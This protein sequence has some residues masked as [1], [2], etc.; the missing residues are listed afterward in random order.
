MPGPSEP[1]GPIYVTASN[2]KAPLNLG[3][4]SSVSQMPNF[5]IHGGDIE[6][7]FV[8]D[9]TCLWPIGASP[10]KLRDHTSSLESLTV[11]PVADILRP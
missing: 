2:Y 6:H 7:S 1:S 5:V 3:Q 9:L 11:A 4:V 10:G 8:E